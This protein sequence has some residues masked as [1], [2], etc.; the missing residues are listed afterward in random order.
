[1]AET[2]ALAASPQR[3]PG[4]VCEVPERAIR[5]ESGEPITGGDKLRTARLAP[6][7][8]AVSLKSKADWERTFC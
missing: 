1:M 4:D 3:P 5:V 8:I 7:G 6:E 2:A